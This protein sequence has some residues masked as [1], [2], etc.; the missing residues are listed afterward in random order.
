MEW[1][2]KEMLMDIKNTMDIIV[3]CIKESDPK[4]FDKVIEKINKGGEEES[5]KK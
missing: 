5:K 4:N 2:T 3:L 1:E